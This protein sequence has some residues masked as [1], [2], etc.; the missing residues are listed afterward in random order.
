MVDRARQQLGTFAGS[1]YQDVQSPAGL[2]AGK[3]AAVTAVGIGCIKY[4]RGSWLII[5]SAL[6]AL[7][8]DGF[9]AGAYPFRAAS[10]SLPPR[11][12]AQYWPP[13]RPRGCCA[14]RMSLRCFST[15]Q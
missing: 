6:S 5:I 12:A 3:F 15:D 9:G 1:L 13:V 14:C 7:A 10:P 4:K 8:A 2:C 11:D